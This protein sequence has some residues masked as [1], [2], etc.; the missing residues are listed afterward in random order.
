MA[1]PLLLLTAHA[2]VKGY[3]VNQASWEGVVRVWPDCPQKGTFSNPGLSCQ[4]AVI[5]LNSY[6]FLSGKT[7]GKSVKAAIITLCV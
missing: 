6:L 7:L 5:T 3:L 2:S 4:T 1:F